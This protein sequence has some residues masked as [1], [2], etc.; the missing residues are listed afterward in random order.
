MGNEHSHM[1]NRGGVSRVDARAQGKGGGR[2]KCMG[3]CGFAGHRHPADWNGHGAYCCAACMNGGGS[4]GR[5]CDKVIF[6][7]SATTFV[8]YHGTS[9]ENARKIQSEGFKPSTDGRLG[10]GVYVAK[11]DKATGF[12]RSYHRHGGSEG[13]VVKCMVTVDDPKYLSGGDARGNYSGHDAVRT[14]YTTSS[15]KPE[16]CVR[17]PGNVKVLSVHEVS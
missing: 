11:E 6:S 10:P 1:D 17:D 9:L 15:N 7:D 13:A 12:A 14:N 2:G 16:W 8:A 5:R 4:H 3:G